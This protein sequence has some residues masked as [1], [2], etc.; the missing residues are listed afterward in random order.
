M[1]VKFPT[2]VSCTFAVE[3]FDFPTHGLVFRHFASKN[4][5]PGEQKPN[6]I[7]LVTLH[8]IS[9]ITMPEAGKT[10]AVL[11]SDGT[12]KAT[13]IGHL[14]YKVWRRIKR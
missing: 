6:S 7:Y 13:T 4:C 1:Y 5:H 11:G 10:L 9:N 3:S 12:G 2:T 8:R 14:I